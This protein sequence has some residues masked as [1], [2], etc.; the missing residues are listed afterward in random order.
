[1]AD[2]SKGDSMNASAHTPSATLSPLLRRPRAATAVAAAAAALACA[3][4][5]AATASSEASAS[6][7]SEPVNASLTVLDENGRSVDVL[8]KLTIKQLAAALH[9]SSAELVAGIEALPGYSSVA[10]LLGEVLNPSATLS[11]VTSALS[12]LGL[13]TGSL[14]QL[15]EARLS[16]LAQDAEG[17]RAL[18]AEILADLGLNGALPTLA[19]ELATTLNDLLEPQ[20]VS[21]TT[22]GAASTLGTTA[23]NLNS[24][25]KA[26]RAIVKPLVSGAPLV[27]ETVEK[28][29]PGTTQVVATPSGGGGLT[30]TTVNSTS[31]PAAAG[32]QGA[33]FG[34]FSV[35]SVKVT[36]AGLI[37]ER[38]FLPK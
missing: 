19:N 38:V 8:G 14:T 10:S 25:L 22:E 16:S 36:K 20:L 27:L 17:L 35:L 37:V 26:A 21:S 24:T 4:P 12:A 23:E 18:V 3:L 13:S 30:F 5:S 33:K 6:V 34:S 9:V 31:A 7:T 32:V 29:L 28:A 2:S 11:Q 1:M 15:I